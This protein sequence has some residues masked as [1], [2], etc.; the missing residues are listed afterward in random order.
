MNLWEPFL[1]SLGQESLPYPTI[2]QNIRFNQNI[3]EFGLN[4]GLVLR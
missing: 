3:S 2:H 1:L 4:L